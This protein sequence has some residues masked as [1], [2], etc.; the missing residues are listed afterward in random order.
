MHIAPTHQMQHLLRRHGRAE[1]SRRLRLLQT[2][3]FSLNDTGDE[4]QDA[5]GESDGESYL[6]LHLPQPSQNGLWEG[7]R[8]LRL[9]DLGKRFGD[10][11]HTCG[12][13]RTRL[14]A[15]GKGRTRLEACGKER[16][17]HDANGK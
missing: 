5:L 6:P 16:T 8:S 7:A 2:E 15:C 11:Q 1:L 17:R 3:L 13:E 4:S 10:T 12:K 14:E 9:A